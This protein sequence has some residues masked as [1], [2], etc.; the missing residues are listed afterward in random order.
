MPADVAAIRSLRES[1]YRFLTL[2]N[3]PII[4]RSVLANG[5]SIDYSEDNSEFG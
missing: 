5:T 4:H 1:L 3:Q 2:A